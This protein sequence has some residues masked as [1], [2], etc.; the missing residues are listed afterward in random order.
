MGKNKKEN[1]NGT[2]ALLGEVLTFLESNKQSHNECDDGWYSC[3]KHS[4]G[5]ADEEQG[6]ECNC[7]ADEYNAKLEALC[8][9]I[10][11]HFA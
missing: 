7:G 2:N 4:E 1:L 11:N 3:P 6:H 5:C 10:R 8:E 9:K